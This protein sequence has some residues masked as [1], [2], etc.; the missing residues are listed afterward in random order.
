MSCVFCG[1]KSDSDACDR[2]AEDMNAEEYQRQ[3]EQEAYEAWVMEQQMAEQALE[4][5]RMDN[6]EAGA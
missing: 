4:D 3:A 2:C 1:A 6:P 5:F